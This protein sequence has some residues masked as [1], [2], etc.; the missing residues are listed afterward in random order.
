MKS[1]GCWLQTVSTIWLLIYFA[2]F[3][4]RWS[5]FAKEKQMQ[6]WFPAA[7]TLRVEAGKKPLTA[8]FIKMHEVKRIEVPLF[9]SLTIEKILE[10]FP[11][12]HDAF[13]YL[14][15]EVDDLSANR[16]FILDVNF[17]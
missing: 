2:D 14:P 5:L 7:N 10:K 9:P 11:A 15:D 12:E 17:L 13:K 16:Q 4:N 6:T 3:F 8:Q 1:S